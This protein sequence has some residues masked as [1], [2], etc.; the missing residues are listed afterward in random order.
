MRSYSPIA[1]CCAL[2]APLALFACRQKPSASTPPAT[3]AATAPGATTTP[4]TAALAAV[5][6]CDQDVSGV[7]V[8]ASDRHFAYRFRDH[9]GV[10]RGEYLARNDDGGLAKPDEPILFELHRTEAALAGVMKSTGP[11]PG[12]RS[13]PVDFGIKVSACEPAA[14]IAVVE[15]EVPITDDCRRA[16][17]ADGG[18][19]APALVEFRFE[20]IEDEP[21]HPPVGGPADH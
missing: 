13:C 20:R 9:G 7:W 8:N 19:V 3:T 1:R 16:R 18:E 5:R 6:F 17:L 11:A 21:D 10:L 14:M 12:G 15:T 2:L 4:G